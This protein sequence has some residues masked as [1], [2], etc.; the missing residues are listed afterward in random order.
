MARKKIFI[1]EDND[2]TRF[3][4]RSVIETT[5]HSV[6]GEAGSFKE[7]I[8]KLPESAADILLLD[9][10]L[11]DKSGLEVLKAFRQTN[12]TTK[13]IVI[14]ALG[15]KKLDEELFNAG[16]DYILRK[17]FSAHGLKRAINKT[18]EKHE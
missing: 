13:I 1:V 9:I 15:Q 5:E 12:K 11:P 3:T 16:T 8:E 10:I 17:P 4:I 7:A 6:S 2:L 18:A 14:T